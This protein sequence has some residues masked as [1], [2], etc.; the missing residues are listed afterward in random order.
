[1]LLVSMLIAGMVTMQATFVVREPRLRGQV[2]FSLLLPVP[3]VIAV[4]VGLVAGPHRVLSLVYMVVAMA[5]GVYLRRFGQRGLGAGN[6]L[7]FGAFF[8]YFLHRQLTL[9][10]AGWIAADLWVGVLAS[11]LVRLAFFRPDPE[12]A[13]A[14]M[15][16]SQRARARRLL[17][18][19]GTVLTETDDRRIGELTERIGRQTIRLNETTL[20]IDA[21]LADARPATAAAEAHRS[22]D[23]ELALSNC[24]RFA[25]AL[26]GRAAPFPVRLAAAT[27]LASVGQPDPAAVTWATAALRAAPSADA[28]ASV[29]A[30]R[31]AAS[32]EQYAEAR[33]RLDDPVGDD[34][35]AGAGGGDFTPAVRLV[36]DWLPGSAPVSTEAASR[37]P[38][39]LRT[40][41]Q[42]AVAGTLAVVAGYLVSPPRLYWAV[43][44]VFVCFI[45]AGNSGEQ[46]R[47]GLLRAGGTAIGI[48]LGDLLVH[49][50]GG[51]AGAS[52]LI[53]LAAMFLG[54]Y[55]IR[56]NYMFMTIGITVMIAQLFVRL[57]EL[58]TQVLLLRLAE[59]AV[60]AGAVV[61]T[62]Y[63]IV[64]LRPQRVL[65]AGVLLWFR[66]LEELVDAVLDRL[67][68]GR[69]PLRP[70]VREVDAAYAALVAAATSLR[71]VTFGRTSTQ[72]TE[73]LAVSSAARRY[74]RSLAALL[75]D[76]EQPPPA[77]DDAGLDAAARQLRA[78]L[79]AIER[80]LTT[81]EEAEYVRSAALFTVAVGH[82]RD[83]HRPAVSMLD[84]LTRLDGA[85]ASLAT[86]LRMPVTDHDTVTA[87]AH[88]S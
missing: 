70:L 14:R 17:A 47:R 63:V 28:H 82:L 21:Q 83:Q 50:T 55:L 46:L 66:A 27:A 44:T 81:G 65:T 77:G 19:A 42:I 3:M 35:I 25:V 4:V 43:L 87:P 73:I 64:P 75:P 38:G 49:V 80:R 48:V 51:S 10:D 69:R 86:L 88:R 5:L 39:Y 7:F 76:G 60:G 37:L 2:I 85:M 78:S 62:V 12:R 26:A 79:D 67:Q 61:V 52:L 33:R 32:V 9:A 8:G 16:R 41:I 56:V 54:I 40:T 31:L 18:L 59:T 45:A 13:L 11:L 30:A 74:A 57:G 6:V 84:D 22:F 53:V 68:G 36:N 58:S 71:P 24:A 72:I 23:A 1:M 29:L 20:M 15:R 34:E